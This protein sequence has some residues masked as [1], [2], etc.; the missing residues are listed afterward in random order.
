MKQKRNISKWRRAAALALSVAIAATFLL[1][2]PADAVNKASTGLTVFDFNMTA[3]P[4]TFVENGDVQYTVSFTMPADLTGYDAVKIAFPPSVGLLFTPTPATVKVNGVAAPSVTIQGMTTV[5]Y[6]ILDN[7][8]F[9]PSLFS[10]SGGAEIELTL[11][12]VRIQSWTSGKPIDNEARLYFRPDGGA[13]PVDLSDYDARTTETV[14]P[15]LWDAGL[16]EVTYSDDDATSGAP[17]VD[18][19]S[20][21]RAGDTVTVLGNVGI[22][23]LARTGYDLVGWSRDI[24]EVLLVSEYASIAVG[25]TITGT[26]E[27]GYVV[28]LIFIDTLG[29][30]REET[31]SGYDLSGITVTIDADGRW[32]YTVPSEPGN[33]ISG[34]KVEEGGYQEPYVKT[35]NYMF[36]GGPN[37]FTM[38]HQDMTLKP[39]WSPTG[40]PLKPII[41]TDRGDSLVYLLWKNA[42]AGG[43]DSYKVKYYETADITTAIEL[44][45]PISGPGGLTYYDATTSYYSFFGPGLKNGVEYTFEVQA[46]VTATGATSEVESVHVTP[47]YMGD[48]GGFNTDLVSVQDNL[49]SP[50]PGGWPPDHGNLLIDPYEVTLALPRDLD[51]VIVHRDHIKVADGASFIMYS[52]FGF[53]NEVILMNRLGSGISWFD[54]IYVYLM[55]TSANKQAVKYYRITVS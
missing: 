20:P 41:E 24:A 49:I 7:E 43:A 55:V 1:V 14:Y 13:F 15:L 4:N 38:P 9:S 18:P 47:I 2:L 27:P 26:G 11:T 50:P 31:P 45:I 33:E 23:P 5:P 25:W 17:P 48:P 36:S 54:E 34:W 35:I 39:I 8:V 21:Y 52:N 37:A 12:N 30:Q 40:A 46:V 32:E 44:E 29:N 6:V 53:T 19:S 42:G 28:K 16:V 3:N 22:P 10:T 51:N